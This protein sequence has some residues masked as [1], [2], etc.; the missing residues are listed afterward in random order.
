M[1]PLQFPKQAMSIGK[2]NV[3]V[4]RQTALSVKILTASM[5]QVKS[6]FFVFSKSIVRILEEW[7]FN[8]FVILVISSF[9]ASHSKKM[10]DYDKAITRYSS[11]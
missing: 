3:I 2:S 10:I 7:S 11:V 5:E 9:L 8:E 4:R 6:S 1:S